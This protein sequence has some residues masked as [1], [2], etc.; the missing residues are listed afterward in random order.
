MRWTR[1]LGFWAASGLLTG[2]ASLP[3]GPGPKSVGR[4][5]RREATLACARLCERHNDAA[6]ARRIYQA[7]IKENPKQVEPYHRLAVLAAKEGNFAEADAYFQKALA[8]GPATAELLSDMG[9]ALY[10]QDRLAEAEKALRRAV[11]LEPNYLAAHNN[12]GLVLGQ[13][14]KFEAAMTAFRKGGS[15]AQ[16]HANLA[17]VHAT[18][19][20]LDLAEKQYSRALSLDQELRPAAEALLQVARYTGSIGRPTTITPRQASGDDDGG[21]HLSHAQPV[22]RSR[23]TASVAA[24]PRK[25]AAGQQVRLPEPPDAAPEASPLPEETQAAAPD[26]SHVGVTPPKHREPF[27]WRSQPGS[28]QEQAGTLVLTPNLTPELP[29]EKPAKPAATQRVP[30]EQAAP[31]KHPQLAQRHMPRRPVVKIVAHE[32]DEDGDQHEKQADSVPPAAA[33][34]ADDANASTAVWVSDD[35]AEEAPMPGRQ[36]NTASRP[37]PARQ[38]HTPRPARRGVLGRLLGGDEPDQAGGF[39]TATDSPESQ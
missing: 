29:A 11:E 37:R 7:L 16:A 21:E 4:A 9:Y 5:E 6:Q 13:Q 20:E 18:R 19:G 32:A 31:P 38:K 15:E 25:S 3:S 22:A 24:K 30:P 17:Y 1:M 2:C 8:A 39:A 14:G 10:L 26:I 12:L 34:H 23:H 27:S 36:N 28:T 33:A 35:T